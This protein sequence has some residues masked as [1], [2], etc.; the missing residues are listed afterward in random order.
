MHI[1]NFDNFS[2]C[3]SKAVVSIYSSTKIVQDYSFSILLL[4]L[5]VISYFDNPQTNN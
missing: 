3:P 4:A 2:R 5:D 1:L